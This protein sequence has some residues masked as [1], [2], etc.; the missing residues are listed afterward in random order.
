[1]PQTKNAICSEKQ[2]EVYQIAYELFSR[3]PKP[4]WVTFFR[5]ILGVD[6]VIRQIYPT[7]QSLADFERRDTYTE[8]LQMLTRLR[9]RPVVCVVSDRNKTEG[10]DR[11][12]DDPREPI[13]VITVRLP[14]SLYEA[15]RIEAHEHHTSVNQLCI[16]KLLQFIENELI[17]K[18]H[19]TASAKR[20]GR[21]K[22]KKGAEKK[23]A[24]A[25]L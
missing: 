23:R 20:L 11:D 15:I 13:R 19:R 6:G 8:I 14:D 10:K 1:M 22:K 24:G 12:E 2:E 17:P 4:D 18:V 7:P 9:E 5:E 16:S 3:D 25:D 21:R